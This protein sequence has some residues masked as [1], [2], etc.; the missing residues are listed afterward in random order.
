MFDEPLEMVVQ[1][2]LAI[3]FTFLNGTSSNTLLVLER[4]KFRTLWLFMK[5]TSSNAFLVL[6][7]FP[8]NKIQV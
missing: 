4:Y 7:V 2:L 8:F 5:G 6:A 1:L 3:N